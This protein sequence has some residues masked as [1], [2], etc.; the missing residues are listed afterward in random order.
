[1]SASLHILLISMHHSITDGGSVTVMQTEL[2]AAY[3]AVCSGAQPSLQ[4]LP[5][6]LADYAA[7]QRSHLQ[8]DEELA[9]WTDML[10]GAP[11]LLELPYDRP[12]PA[13]FSHRGAH[14]QLA[15]PNVAASDLTELAA[16]HQTTLFV[17]ALTALQVNLLEISQLQSA[18]LHLLPRMYCMRCLY[19]P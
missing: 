11:P 3:A 6:Q 1:M 10:A 7:W 15:L 18:V 9:W 19:K 13:V 4:R 14:V 12:R 16:Q 8:L 5:V 2:G 17:V